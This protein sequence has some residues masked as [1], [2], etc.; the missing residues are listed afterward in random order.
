MPTIHTLIP[1][2]T[3]QLGEVLPQ[4]KREQA[5]IEQTIM[6]EE[7]NFLRTLSKG[8]LKIEHWIAEN[9]PSE[10]GVMDGDTAFELLDTY[11]FPPD[12]TALVLSEKG[13]RMDQLGFEN[14]MAVQRE[15]SRIAT[16]SSA[17]D[18]FWA[19]WTADDVGIN[20]NF[21]GY[22][23][24]SCSTRIIRCRTIQSTEGEQSQ[25]VLETTPFYAESGG[26]VGD[27]GVLVG[28]DGHRIQVLNVTKENNL[29]IHWVDSLPQD[30]EQYFEASVNLQWRN[31]VSAH[32]SATH[33]LHSA[34]RLRLGDHVQQKGSLVTIDQ[35]RFDFSQPTK[36]GHD[37]LKA[38]EREVNQAVAM[39]WPLVEERDLS[40]IDA[41]NSGA[42]ALFGEKYGDK[43]RVI[44]FGG[45]YSKELCGGTHVRNSAQI[46]W[47]K[48]ITETA[49]ASG[50]RRIEAVCGPA[51]MQWVDT[52]LSTL[53]EA[54]E[55][56]KNPADLPAQ[57]RKT[58]AEL[59]L[60]RKKLEQWNQLQMEQWMQQWSAAWEIRA[61][62]IQLLVQMC[63]PSQSEAL[64]VMANRLRASSP[65][66]CV[67]LGAVVEDKTYL[68]CALGDQLAKVWNAGKLVRDFIEPLGGQGG[69]QAH[70]AMAGA[71]NSNLQAQQATQR[72]QAA[73]QKAELFLGQLSLDL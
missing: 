73:I 36:I 11:G 4:L 21:V 72:L 56:L 23:Q 2:L 34:L 3:D 59:G 38:I 15:R 39:A 10:G 70:L 54:H 32:H 17:G 19:S 68:A 43:V 63:E 27:Q 25:V 49:I 46:G 41:V 61:N 42:T 13:Y 7:S 37:D 67:V 22:D 24:N 66:S 6:A 40:M 1:V 44:S 64:K 14:A 28:A 62:G 47:F 30:L 48:I 53:Q 16:K 71:P 35:L 29:W 45:S 12:L 65:M 51:A 69:G 9:D 8:L 52:Q 50:I 26:Q 31:G 60:V 58:V 18:W 5:L 55:I 33:L 20:G 57:L